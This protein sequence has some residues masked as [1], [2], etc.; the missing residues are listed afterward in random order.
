[1]WF[2]I[3]LSKE[4]DYIIKEKTCRKLVEQNISCNPNIQSVI[5]AEVVK[6]SSN[7]SNNII[8]AISMLSLVIAVICLVDS[9]TKNFYKDITLSYLYAYNLIMKHNYK[10]MRMHILHFVSFKKYFHTIYFHIYKS[11]IRCPLF[12]Q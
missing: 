10:V 9:K 7:I 8:T 12:F 3:A 2:P 11:Y 1:M 6:D 4:E 5:N